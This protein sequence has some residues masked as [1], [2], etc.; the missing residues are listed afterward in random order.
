MLFYPFEKEFYLP[1][2]PKE[3]RYYCWREPIAKVF[4]IDGM[5]FLK[6]VFFSFFRMFL[7]E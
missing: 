3:F 6:S 4:V 5:V 2:T 7:P 1:A